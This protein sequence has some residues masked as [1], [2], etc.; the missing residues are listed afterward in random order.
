M[1][2]K[3]KFMPILYSQT[4]KSRIFLNDEIEKKYLW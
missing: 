4:K 2:L 1:K 3:T